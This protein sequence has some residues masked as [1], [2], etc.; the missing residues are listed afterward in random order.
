MSRITSFLAAAGL[1][2]TI[3]NVARA[4]EGGFYSGPI[5]GSD[6]RS[7]ILSTP[8]TLAINLTASPIWSNLYTSSDGGP[9]PTARSVAFA[10]QGIGGGFNYVYPWTLAG[11]R[12]A[13]KF[14]DQYYFTCYRKLSRQQCDSGNNDPYMDVLEYSFHAGMFGAKPPAPHPGALKLPYGLQVAPAFSLSIP[15]GRYTI[16]DLANQ[17]H[18]TWIFV[19]NVSLTYTTGPDMSFFD[20]TEIST[21]LYY[22]VSADNPKTGYRNGDTFVDD[23]AF[24]QRAHYWQFGIAGTVATATTADSL[25][26]VPRPNDGNRLFD[27]LIGPVIQVD[28]PKWHASF[29][30]KGLYDAVSHNRLDHNIVVFRATFSL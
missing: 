15:V 4:A 26:G 11:G 24:T 9:S 23:F 19:P 13:T 8:G 14:Q 25:H 10:A 7:A 20:A 12:F 28:V 29:G 3:G 2:M 18:N 16:T 21:R 5:G 27:F 30:V 6:I 22:E 1:V 17:G